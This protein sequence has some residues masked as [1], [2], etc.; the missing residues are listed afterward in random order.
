MTLITLSDEG[1]WS[2][3]NVE[4]RLLTDAASYPRTEHSATLLWKSKA[5]TALRSAGQRLHSVQSSEGSSRHS[6]RSPGFDPR[7]IP[8]RFV[9][10]KLALGRVFLRALRIYPSAPL[11]KVPTL[12]LQLLSSEQTGKVWEPSN[13]TGVLADI[14]KQEEKNPPLC[15]FSDV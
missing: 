10:D 12:I 15:K 1:S 4:I 5:R 14:G 9:V 7:P 13:G 11:H 6:P 2:L 3:R 8:V